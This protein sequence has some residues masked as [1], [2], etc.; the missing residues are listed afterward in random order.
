[1][2]RIGLTIALYVL[3]CGAFAQ[4]DRDD[5][6]QTVEQISTGIV[7]IRIDATRAF[8]TNWNT[9]SQATGFVVD[10]ERGLILTNR[11]VVTP[12]P[13]V[14]EAVFLN[15]EEVALQPIYRDPVH[16]FGF[17]RFDPKALRFIEPAT[18]KLDPDGARVGREIRVIGNDAGE[19]LSILAGTLARLDRPAPQYGRGNYND[20]NTFYFQ[21][22]SSTSGGSSGSPVVDVAGNVIALNA[23]GSNGA[24]SS[25]FLPLDRIVHALTLIQGDQRVVRGT[26]QTTFVRKPYDELRRLGLRSST[27]TRLRERFPDDTGMLTVEQVLPGSPADGALSP[28]D[29]LV[30]VNDQLLNA[31]VP[32]EAILDAS[33]G[34]TVALSIERG[35]EPL[36]LDVAVTDL[37]TISPDRY[38]EFGDAVMN[39]LSY[40][41]G[42]HYNLPPTGVFVANPGYMLSNAA[43]PRGAVILEVDGKPVPDIDAMAQI[44]NQQA[45]DSRVQIRF[46]TLDAPRQEIPRI[47]RIDRTW[48]AGRICERDDDTGLWPCEA[49]PD[50][51][52][53]QAD[54]GGSTTFPPQ[55]D[56]RADRISRSLVLVNFD[57]PFNI[58][59]IGE[60]HYYG[61]GL[62]VD[63]SRGLVLVD[64]NTVP[65]GMG[66]VTITFA[67]SLEIPAAVAYVHPLHNLA[68][69]QYD[70][71]LIGDTPVRDASFSDNA[72]QADDQVW[73]VGLTPAHRVVLQ[74]TRVADVDALVSPIS[75][76]LKFRD[77][78]LEV[79][80]VVNAPN[81]DGVLSDRRGR[82]VSTWSSFGGNESQ[83]MR[84]IPAYVVQ[85]FVEVVREGRAFYSLETELGLVPLASA[86]KL[87]LPESWLDRLE[88]ANGE[89]RQALAISRVAAATDA[90][91]QLRTGDIVLTID[92]ELVTTFS[93]FSRAIDSDEVTLEIWRDDALQTVTVGTEVLDGRSA[94]RVVQWAGALLQ[95]PYRELARQRGIEPSGVYVAYFNYGSP[96]TRYGLWAGRRVVEV[97]GQPTPDLDR[98]LAVVKDA[99]DR[100]SLRIK[101]L[102]WNNLPQVITLKLDKQY[103]RGFVVQFED[104]DWRRQPLP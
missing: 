18:L 7:S 49:L 64:R 2:M 99:E 81:V 48:F 88:Q 50:G 28:G 98:F 10:A 23:G 32:L 51:P 20:F 19:K 71:A 14:A 95:D 93:E 45:D 1:M 9:S 26:L 74:E 102:D 16:D 68:M 53:R 29:V 25:F 13:V 89:R 56:P 101:T 34:A 41:Q 94:D 46:V 21:A 40:Q 55:S 66:D 72:V 61:T 6:A 76:S 39:T 5:W 80:S 92:G 85:D 87:G 58:S 37:A 90:A 54:S 11:H 104:G 59:G 8:D 77:T 33:V 65:I 24:A 12:G 78:N 60:R 75:R 62:I 63:Q 73:V 43:V 52:A 84:G 17:Y 67:G 47:V 36:T 103:W 97:N 69:L 70:P 42:R 96:A 82:I 27:E 3:S 57:L 86:R 79:I 91:K 38:L 4:S 31:F 100:E 35:G 22:A 83:T 15:N 30:A 44:L